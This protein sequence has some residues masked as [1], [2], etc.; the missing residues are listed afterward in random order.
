[1][2]NSTYIISARRTAIGSFGGTLRDVS[3]RSLG[4]TII[5]DAFSQSSLKPEDIEEVLLGNVLQAGQNN[6][7]RFCAVDAGIPVTSPAL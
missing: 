5:K 4:T 7:A 1:M 3:L 6:I 2:K